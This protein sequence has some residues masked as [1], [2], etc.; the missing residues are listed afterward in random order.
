MT[1]NSASHRVPRNALSIPLLFHP[2]R[3][4]ARE[5]AAKNRT[6]RPGWQAF[7]T[8]VPIGAQRSGSDGERRHKGTAWSFHRKVETEQSGLC[9]DEAVARWVLPVLTEPR[10]IRFSSPFRNPFPPCIPAS[11]HRAVQCSGSRQ[12]PP[13][14]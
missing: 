12:N 5:A 6:W 10:K 3:R 14:S 7:R 8:G 1:N 11:T 9:S 2:S 4:L 13:M